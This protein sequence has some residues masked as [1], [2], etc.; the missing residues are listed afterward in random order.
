MPTQTDAPRLARVAP[1]KLWFGAAG[2][3]VT[4]ALHST[5]CEII[6]SKACQNNLGSWGWLSPLGVRWLMAAITLI[7]LG[8]AVAA[9]LTSFAN[10]RGLSQSPSLIQ[11]AGE[12]RQ[13]F[14]ALVGVFSSVAFLI[15]ILWAGIPL[16]I[17]DI[18]V[19]AR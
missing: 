2:A 19:K 13:Q 8:I 15:G 6:A 16:I 1:R 7:A 10:W 4:W 3:A 5:I 17:L 14:M 11:A 18:C 12:R 9:G